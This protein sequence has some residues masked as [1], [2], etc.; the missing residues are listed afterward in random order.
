MQH[1]GEAGKLLLHL[2]Q[3]IEAQLGLSTGLELISTVAGTDSDSQ[4]VAA[5]LIHKFLHLLGA[6]V[7]GILGG[8]VYLVLDAGQSAKLS[9]YHHAMIVGIFH[10]LAGQGDI[11]SKGLGGCVDHH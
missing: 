5:G 8:Y 10:H 6:S 11:L 9:F 7:G 3:H 1:D 4:G 2:L